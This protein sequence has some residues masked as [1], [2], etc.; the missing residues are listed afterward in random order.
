MRSFPPLPGFPLTA[1]VLVLASSLALA[2]AANAQSNTERMANDWYTPSHNYDLVHQRI[3]LGAFDWDSTAFTGRVSTTLISLRSGMDSVVLDAGSL[4]RI[5][6]V[7]DARDSTMRTGRSGDSL[8][9]FLAQPAAFGD[10]LSFTIDYHGKVQNGRGLTFI[11]ADGRP[12][13]RQQIWSQG[14]STNNHYWFP[15]YDHPHD[16]MTWEMVV[17]VP[18]GY[19]AISNGRVV[20]DRRLPDGTRTLHWSQEKPASTYLV[21]LVIGQYARVHDEWRGIPVDYFVYPEDT[22]LARPLFGATPD[23]MEVYSDLTGVSYPWAKY[24]QTTVADFFGGM[25][26]VSATTLVDWLPDARAYHDHPWYKYI[27]VPH[28]LAHQWFGNYTTIDN[29]AN[30]WLNEGFAEFMPG[31]YWERKLGRHAGDD[32]Y[33]DEYRQFMAIDQRRRMPLASL[34]SNNI[35]PKGALVIR[36]LERYL[37][38]ERFWASVNRYLTHHA[39]GTATSDDLRQAVLA[40]TGE[41]LGWFWDQWIYQ[42][43]YPTFT[44]AASY[45]SSTSKLTLSVKQT[46][47]DSSQADSTGLRYTTPEVFRMPVSIRVGT[48]GGDVVRTAWLG[49]R[50]QIIEIDSL[51]GA[52]TM[53]VFDDGNAIL[54]RLDFE[55]PTPWLATQLARDAD[56]WNR[57]WVISRLAQRTTDSTAA[58]ALATAATESDYYLTRAEAAGALASFPAPLAMPAL[59]VALRDTSARVRHA[60]VSALGT[61]GGAGALALARAAFDG[62]P[63]YQVRAAALVA[64]TRLDQNARRDVVALALDSPSYRDVIQNTALDVIAVSADTSFIPQLERM[65][66]TQPRASLTLGSLAARGSTHALELLGNHLNDDRDYVRGWVVTAFSQRVPGNIAVP[67]LESVFATLKYD[68]T[69]RLVGEMMER[70]ASNGM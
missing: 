24:A 48:A 13:R 56:L 15:T 26:N 50:E 23:M 40:A 55:Q 47:S 22:A 9:V 54:K 7:S 19:T 2:T 3:E 16:K 59:K 29:W 45:D 68:D 37:G 63:S 65:L 60:A 69:R 6:R 4:L 38:P 10:T 64:V 61:I 1:A 31:A 49:A 27:L 39:L 18:K 5:D 30:M 36:M 34:A 21:S 44:V 11:E 52:P 35:Y 70:L 53:V 58:V 62:D 20:G 8:V 66:G 46:Q 33:L 57:S 67:R 41:N 25:E 43:G 14:E 51:G 28:E 17:T 42:A 32:Y 12:G